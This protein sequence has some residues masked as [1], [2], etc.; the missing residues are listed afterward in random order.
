MKMP[1]GELNDS[2]K[3]T[4]SYNFE[5]PLKSTSLQEN[6]TAGRALFQ[7]FKDSFERTFKEFLEIERLKKKIESTTMSIA[8]LNGCIAKL[9]GLQMSYP[10]IVGNG[11]SRASIANI[12]T[13]PPYGYNKNYV[14]PMNYSVKKRFKPHSNYKKSMNNKVLYVCTIEND[15][16]VVTADD[17]FVWK[18]SNVW[19]DVKRDLGIVDE[20][21]SIE[22]FMALTNP[23]VI[24]MIESIG[25]VSNFEGYI[26]FSKRAQ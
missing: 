2:F 20:F 13:F 7:E 10:I 21:D 6:D 25:D 16:I 15:G 18:G 8:L 1:F 17:G 26:Q 22:D 11:L 24:K 4:S 5:D 14:Y 19:R 12:G 23:T 9:N 3:K